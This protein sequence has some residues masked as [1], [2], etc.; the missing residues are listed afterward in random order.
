MPIKHP[1]GASGRRPF[2][3]GPWELKVTSLTLDSFPL[4]TR[5]GEGLRQMPIRECNTKV[6]HQTG[7]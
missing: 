6:T 5:A 7:S 4:K 1:S 2:K 3:R